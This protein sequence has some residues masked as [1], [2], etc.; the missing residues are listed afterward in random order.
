MNTARIAAILAL[1]TPHAYDALAAVD[2]KNANLPV[3][4]RYASEGPDRPTARLDVANSGG[5]R[6]LVV[7]VVPRDDVPEGRCKIEAM[8]PPGQSG[9]PILDADEH[10]LVSLSGNEGEATISV[11]VARKQ[12]PDADAIRCLGTW[13][14]TRTAM[15]E[16]LAIPRSDC[17]AILHD[18][19][20]ASRGLPNARILR[21]AD[22]K[23]IANETDLRSAVFLE[24]RLR[25][26]ELTGKD[27][28][29]ALFCDSDLS[30]ANLS[31]AD[32]SGALLDAGTSLRGADLSGAKLRGTRIVGADLSETIMTDADLTGA[33]LS[34][35]GSGIRG[36]PCASHAFSPTDVS[37]A[38][39]GGAELPVLAAM[40]KGVP[41][42]IDGALVPADDGTLSWALGIMRRNDRIRIV[43]PPG[44]SASSDGIEVSA[45]ELRGALAAIDRAAAAPRPARCGAGRKTSRLD[46]AICGDPWLSLAE[47]LLPKNGGKAKDWKTIAQTCLDERSER[48][49]AVA[50]RDSDR[51]TAAKGKRETEGECL[52]TAASEILATDAETPRP[53]KGD[54]SVDPP[55]SGE[56]LAAELLRLK[57]PGLAKLSVSETPDGKLVVSARVRSENGVCAMRSVLGERGKGPKFPDVVGNADFAL[58]LHPDENKEGCDEN[59]AWPA[60]W[61]RIQRK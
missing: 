27:L 2:A 34:C 55:I 52:R 58:L 24:A 38:E 9:V 21:G 20:T 33:R 37:G 46:A 11:D 49:D 8:I 16:N 4:G 23:T 14:V 43:P 54:Y 22:R 25:G 10:F 12:E 51:R 56:P 50:R 3:Q 59:A 48:F 1:L 7:L 32:L 41:A 36:T 31:G 13:R 15:K 19:R 61:H 60:E 17:A 40:P 29:G 57:A 35:P 39:L 42:S 5:G 44:R 53:E 30:R 6:L 28:S 18:G 26:A 45:Q 47:R